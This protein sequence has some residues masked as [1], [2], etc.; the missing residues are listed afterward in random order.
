MKMIEITCTTAMFK[1]MLVSTNFVL[2]FL[3][4]RRTC[5]INI[6]IKVIVNMSGADNSDK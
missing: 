3:K 2:F 5:K 6:M 1:T 4:V